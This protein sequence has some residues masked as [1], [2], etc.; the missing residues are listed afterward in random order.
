[1]TTLAKRIIIGVVAGLLLV[2]IALA[3]VL[4]GT[5][6]YGWKAAQRAGNEA[7]TMQDL[8]T[9]AAVEIQYYNTHSQT[10]GTLDQLIKENMLT[11]KFSGNPA[12]VDGYIFILSVSPKTVN[13]T[14]L[15]ILNADPQSDNAGKNHFCIDSNSSTIHVNPD[16][17]AGADDPSFGK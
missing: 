3:A 5:G 4:I 1:M 6:F 12:A 7:A 8:K 9:I 10:F 17:P 16:R 11:S 13:Q 14:S 15:Y 2:V